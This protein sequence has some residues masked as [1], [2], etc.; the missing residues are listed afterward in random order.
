M[1]DTAATYRHHAV[2]WLDDSEPTAIAGVK[3][4]N[5]ATVERF[6]ARDPPPLV[7]HRDHGTGLKA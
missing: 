3:R 1:G 7:A 5:R 2:E 4:D 6:D